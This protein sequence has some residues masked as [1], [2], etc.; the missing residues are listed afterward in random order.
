MSNVASHLDRSQHPQ[1]GDTYVMKITAGQCRAARALLGWTQ[2]ELTARSNVSQKTIADFER[3][4]SA[5]Y[6]RT[7]RDLLEAFEAGG[8][9]FIEPAEGVT[10]VGLAL[11]WGVEE[12][13]RLGTAQG[14]GGKGKGAL[15]ALPWDWEGEDD[16]PLPPLD[17]TD[18]DRAEQIEH[19]RSRPEAWAKLHEVSRQCLLR[20]MGVERL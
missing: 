5:P 18:D 1:C 10:G 11:N 4:A 15:D 9:R 16:E 12:P 7:L 20:A 14:T 19:W 6:N 13:A 8:L 2:Q 3:G 17:W